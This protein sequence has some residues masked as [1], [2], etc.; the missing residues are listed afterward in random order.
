MGKAKVEHGMCLHAML[1]A[2]FFVPQHVLGSAVL[3]W[4]SRCKG[5]PANC[6]RVGMENEDLPLLF[7]SPEPQEKLGRVL[8]S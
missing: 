4:K 5:R 2:D 3:A 7:W 6:S 1:Q 8:E